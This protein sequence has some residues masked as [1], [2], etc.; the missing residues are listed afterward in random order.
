V[1]IGLET[2]ADLWVLPLTGARE[3]RPLLRTRFDE[4]SSSFSPDG[5]FLA[6][7][8]NETNRFETYVAP[9]P[10]MSPKWQVSVDGGFA[11][12]WSRDG[13]ELYYTT[14]GAVMAVPI[15]T[16]PGFKAGTPRRLL[17]DPGLVALTSTG[18]GLLV[19]RGAEKGPL[20]PLHL[21]LGWFEELTSLASGPS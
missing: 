18:A 2:G 1:E 19:V 20:P 21:V 14:E 3:P 13:R 5:R 9:F 4:E 8:S 10:A 15:S 17:T 16:V 11:P 7:D 12:A 6:Y